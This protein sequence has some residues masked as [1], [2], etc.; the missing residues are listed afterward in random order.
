MDSVKKVGWVIFI[1]AAVVLA[2]VVLTAAQPTMVEIVT[3]ANTTPNIENYDG[4]LETVNA[5]PLILYFVPAVL[6]FA[7]VIY[8]LKH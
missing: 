4:T 6:G 5:M 2:Y 8:V 7:A 3:S 1:V